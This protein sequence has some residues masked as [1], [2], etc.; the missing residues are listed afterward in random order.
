MSIWRL[1][2]DKCSDIGQRKMFVFDIEVSLLLI[3]DLEIAVTS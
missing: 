3:N 1:L 2:V